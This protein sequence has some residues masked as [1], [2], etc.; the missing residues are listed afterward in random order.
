MPPENVKKQKVRY[1]LTV[2]PIQKRLHYNGNHFN[3]TPLIE[4]ASTIFI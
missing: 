1:C 4:S 2:E 3:R